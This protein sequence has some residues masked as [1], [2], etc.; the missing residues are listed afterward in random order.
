MAI[1]ADDTLVGVVSTTQPLFPGN[2]EHMNY[3]WEIPAEMQ[4]SVVDIRVAAD[5]TGDG[6]GQNNECDEDNNEATL[7]DLTCGAVN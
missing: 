4:D 6:S 3:T 7:D 1:Y 5:D 2:L